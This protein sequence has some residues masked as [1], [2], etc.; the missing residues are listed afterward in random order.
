MTFASWPKSYFTRT[1]SYEQHFKG[2]AENRN[3]Y[4]A[5]IA[6]MMNSG[7]H[8][9]QSKSLSSIT[10]MYICICIIRRRTPG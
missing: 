9:V 1:A 8:F 3:K 2:Q 4:A 5:A 7:A 6:V 10:Y